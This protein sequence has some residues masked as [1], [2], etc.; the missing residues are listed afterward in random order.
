MKPIIQYSAF[1][2]IILSCNQN[3]DDPLKSEMRRID[4]NKTI[5]IS[6]TD[7]SLCNVNLSEILNPLYS[8]NNKERNIEYLDTLRKIINIHFENCKE[9]W[10]LQWF[11]QS[12]SPFRFIDKIESLNKAEKAFNGF[13][14]L[15]NISFIFENNAEVSEYCSGSLSNMALFDPDKFESFLNKNHN[16]DQRKTIIEKIVF[17]KNSDYT[18]FLKKVSGSKYYK[19]IKTIFEK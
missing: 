14:Y 10:D 2:L 19:E 16:F 17:E 12:V 1:I 15:Y 5:L 9:Q 18:I 4:S 7:T 3:N 8:T 11:T 6:K 13:E